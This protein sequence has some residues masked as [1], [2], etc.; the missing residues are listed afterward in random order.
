MELTRL[1]KIEL[2]KLF[3]RKGTWIGFLIIA[4]VPIILSLYFFVVSGEDTTIKGTDVIQSSLWLGKI[5]ATLFVIIVSVGLMSGEAKDKTLRVSLTNPV[6]RENV[7]LAKFLAMVVYI[8]TVLLFVSLIGALP[9]IKI[10][11]LQPDADTQ[12]EA[13]RLALSYLVYVCEL[14]FVASFCLFVSVLT[15]SPMIAYV[16]GFVFN[17]QLTDTIQTAVIEPLWGMVLEKASIS[18][19]PSHFTFPYFIG[20]AQQA[21]GGTFLSTDIDWHLLQKSLGVV[22]I[23]I[24]AFLL[25]ATIIFERKDIKG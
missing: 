16:I 15:D 14:T 25:V 9:G 19:L 11:F 23:Y 1:V 21:I 22:G 7:F 10:G 6:S 3:S 2:V 24:L 5:F 17:N 18:Y 20:Q 13:I 8:M 4:F 12:K